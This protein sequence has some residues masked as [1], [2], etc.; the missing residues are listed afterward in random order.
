MEERSKEEI[1]KIV[2]KTKLIVKPL[3]LGKG[4]IVYPQGYYFGHI[5]NNKPEDNDGVITIFDQPMKLKIKE[6]DNGEEPRFLLKIKGKWEGGDL[7]SGR[8]TDAEDRELFKMTWSL[9]CRKINLEFT[10]GMS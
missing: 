4:L 8:G 2:E 3:K 5:Q 9:L 1:P 7:K 10:S 6:I